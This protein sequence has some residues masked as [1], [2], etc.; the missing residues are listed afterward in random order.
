MTLH[1]GTSAVVFR[2][3]PGASG[4]G[5]GVGVRGRTWEDRAGGERVLSAAESAHTVRHGNKCPFS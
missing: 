5:V 4:G 3:A 1:K 2:V